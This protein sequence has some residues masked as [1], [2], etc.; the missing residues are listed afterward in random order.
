M[1]ILDSWNMYLFLAFQNKVVF[2]R[3]TIICGIIIIIVIIPMI[4]SHHYLGTIQY[5]RLI[6]SLVHY[7]MISCHTIYA[8]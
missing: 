6:M 3:D 4:D 8:T 7:F 2:R 1:A 5:G